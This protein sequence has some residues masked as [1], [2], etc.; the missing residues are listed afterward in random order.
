M[1]VGSESLELEKDRRLFKSEE[2]GKD[3]NTRGEK[4]Q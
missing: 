1:N 4:I 2:K 3:G